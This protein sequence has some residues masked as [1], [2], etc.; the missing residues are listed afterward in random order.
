[1]G[2]RISDFDGVAVEEFWVKEEVTASGEMPT[3]PITEVE[4]LVK[5]LASVWNKE[6]KVIKP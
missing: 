6:K 2:A 5:S 3:D 1:M 4:M